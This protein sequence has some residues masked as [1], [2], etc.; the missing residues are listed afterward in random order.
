MDKPKVYVVI[1]WK[2]HESRVQAYEIVKEWYAKNLPEATVVSLT[3]SEVEWL[4]SHTRNLGVR[5]AE[6]HGA[7]IVILNDADTFPDK[8]DTLLQTIDAAMTDD[9]IH[10]PY[11]E[12]RFYKLEATNQYYKTRSF[13]NCAFRIEHGSNAGI[14]VF[15]PSSWW[16]LGGMDEKFKKWGYE[17]T[18]FEYVHTLV[19]G[20]PLVKHVGIIHA[21]DHERTQSPE[22][23][24]QELLDNFKIYQ[25]YLT[26][27]DPNDIIRFVS[28]PS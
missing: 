27:T 28:S 15:K 16:L 12:Y 19:H 26:I 20:K 9:F 17:D 1:P 8:I 24:D 23:P 14:W 13:M 11:T 10:N 2:Y 5:F 22:S 18:A 3:Y 4:P 21:L 6:E 25:Q 7:D